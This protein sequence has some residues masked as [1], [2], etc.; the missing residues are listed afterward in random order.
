MTLHR[1]CIPGHEQQIVNLGLQAIEIIDEL[2][3]G[4]TTLD[5]VADFAQLEHCQMDRCPGISL[6][7]I[8]TLPAFVAAGQLLTFARL[9]T[10]T[11]VVTVTRH[12][13]FH[14]WKSIEWEC[15]ASGVTDIFCVHFFLLHHD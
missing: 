4:L 13:E 3:E 7:T 8:A 2:R 14:V 5:A 9:A 11:A 10:F 6:T 15:D 1:V 12:S